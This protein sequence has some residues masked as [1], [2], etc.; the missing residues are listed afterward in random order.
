MENNK[1]KLKINN[2]DMRISIAILICY[3]TATILNQIGFLFS[4][5]GRQYEVIQNMTACIACLLCCQDNTKISFLSGV[6][7]LIITMIGG[8]VGIIVIILDN[9]IGNDWI[10]VMMVAIGIIVTLYLCKIAKVPYINARIGG[11]T[12]ILVT[13]TFSGTGR[14]WYALFRLVSTFFGVMVVLLV[15]YL[16]QKCSKMK[17]KKKVI[18]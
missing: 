17:L 14:I 10:M 18:I 1:E 15:T 6:N 2:L 9:L 16:F 3:L 7:R 11:V 5:E 8:G 12:F 4:Y 13:T